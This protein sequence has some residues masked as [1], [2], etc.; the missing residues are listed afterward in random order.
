[1]LEL[2]LILT[3]AFLLALSLTRTMRWL[4]PKVG[5]LDRPDGQRKLHGLA[6]PLGGGVAIFCRGLTLSGCGLRFSES[7]ER[8]VEVGI[9]EL[10]RA[11]LRSPRACRRWTS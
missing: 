8:R 5:L 10:G 3:V 4:A 9:A 6:T 1:M 11:F 2:A 7:L